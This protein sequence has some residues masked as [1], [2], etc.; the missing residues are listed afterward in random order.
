MEPY[1][2]FLELWQL[3]F[4]VVVGLVTGW[5]G[6]ATY[7]SRRIRSIS[8]DVAIEVSAPHKETMGRVDQVERQLSHV[9]GDV[10]TLRQ[11]H[12]AIGRRMSSI[13]ATME[14]VARKDDLALLAREF[15]E[16][17]GS[18]LSELRVTSGQVDT[19]Y[20]ALVRANQDT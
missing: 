7:F 8:T 12:A 6:L 16:F 4:G 11:D 14:G 10:A 2:G 19:L 5:A 13:E 18:A 3:T 9:A 15:A 1:T 20:R 17:R